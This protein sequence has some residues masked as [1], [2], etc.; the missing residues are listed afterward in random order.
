MAYGRMDNRRSCGGA[1][2]PDRM[3][4]VR[5]GAIRGEGRGEQAENERARRLTSGVHPTKAAAGTMFRAVGELKTGCFWPDQTC[6][7]IF[8]E[9][10]VAPPGLTYP[11]ADT[12]TVCVSAKTPFD[13]E[14]IV[15]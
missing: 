3:Y 10:D 4:T 1:R 11:P 13:A 15:Q 6:P 5:R 2:G 9:R 14:R 12:C 7:F 8:A